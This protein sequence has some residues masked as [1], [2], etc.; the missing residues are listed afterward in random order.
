MFGFYRSRKNPKIKQNEKKE[1]KKRKGK[2]IQ[3]I[4]LFSNND[5]DWIK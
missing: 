4:D 5:S 2:Q 3:N 1:K